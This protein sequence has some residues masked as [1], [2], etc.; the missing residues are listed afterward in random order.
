MS[1]LL[2]F[3]FLI[4]FDGKGPLCYQSGIYSPVAKGSSWNLCLE[5]E[6]FHYVVFFQPVLNL[7]S[8]CVSSQRLAGGSK[9][10]KGQVGLFCFF[11]HKTNIFFISGSAVYILWSSDPWQWEWYSLGWQLC[12]FFPTKRLACL[13]Y[14]LQS[15][16]TLSEG[17][18]AN[19]LLW[20]KTQVPCQYWD[21]EIRVV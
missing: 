3:Y 9:Y 7:F 17:L 8:L 5:S 13:F 11:S 19:R 15:F 1:A 14:D 20:D 10:T 16:K 6:L 12:F 2:C 4:V 21:K 18:F